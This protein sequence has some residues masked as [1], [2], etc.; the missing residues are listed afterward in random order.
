MS[1]DVRELRDFYETTLGRIARHH[2]ARQINQMWPNAG[3]QRIIGVGFASPYLK[4]FHEKSAT[5][6]CLMPASQGVI[7]WPSRQQNRSVLVE[8]TALPLACQSVDRVLCI[9][10]LEHAHDVRNTLRELWR[11]LT[12]NGR[13]L[14]VTPNRRSLWSQR[15]STPFGHGH[16]YTAT[17]LAHLLKENMFTPVSSKHALFVLPFSNRLLFSSNNLIESTGQ[18]FF[19]KLGGV[20][21][22]E[23]IKQLYAA[24]TVKEKAFIEVPIFSGT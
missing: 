6:A 14:I 21:C 4:S 22:M 16:P 24:T 19:R 17:Q 9:H 3:D 2:I 8:E 1:T 7:P 15:V 10:G 12:P 11:V 5:T 20:I 23:A 13:L 18:R